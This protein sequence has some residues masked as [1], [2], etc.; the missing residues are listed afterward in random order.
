MITIELYN[1][2]WPIYFSEE[3]KKIKQVLGG[4]CLTVH[5]IG[6]TS[7]I[8]LPAKP[9]IDMVPVV[10]DILQVDLCNDGM[11]Q[12]DYVIKGENGILFRRF[13][14][15]KHPPISFN[16]HVYQEN[17]PEIVHYLKFKEFM[18]THSEARLDYAKLKKELAKK[19]P[20]DM[21]EYVSG[22]N[23]FVQEINQRAGCQGTRI[24]HALLKPEW[25]AY[26]TILNSEFYNPLHQKPILQS[27]HPSSTSQ[28]HLIF[29]Q[30]S[31]L[32]GAAQFEFLEHTTAILRALAIIKNKQKQGFGSQFLALLELWIKHQGCS[33][34][35][36]HAPLTTE[37]FFKKTGYNPLSF[38][39]PAPDYPAISLGKKV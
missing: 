1:P 14:Q 13:F 30:G 19:Y 12:L 39:V 9:V 2:N 3:A 5:H 36:C 17:N 18:N 8:G 23:Q 32:M 15:K 31:L 4:N 21:Y 10:K 26:Y 29:S 28:A 6:S 35:V 34:L 27:N 37:S 11:E 22:K 7:I 38:N 33:Y 24:V 25:A 16:V 20:H